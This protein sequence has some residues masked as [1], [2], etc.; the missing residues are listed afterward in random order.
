VQA[1]G[2][3]S[4]IMQAKLSGQVAWPSTG[5]ATWR[6]DLN[7]MVRALG[8]WVMVSALLGCASSKVELAPAKSDGI[9]VRRLAPDQVLATDFSK[10]TDLD[11]P[12]KRRT[13]Y[14][15]YMQDGQEFLKATSEGTASMYRW[16]LA[17]P[18]EE[19]GHVQFSWKVTQ[20]L[21][22]ANIADRYKDD[23]PARL[24]LAFEGNRE[25]FS[26][27]DAVL[28]ELT[29][30][31]TGEPMPYATLMYV[32]CAACT[33]DRVV[34]HGRTSRI[35]YIE[36][37]VPLSQSQEWQHFNRD[38]AKDYAMAFA[39]PMGPLESVGTMTDTDNTKGQATTY[40]GPIKLMA[41]KVAAP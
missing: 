9:V 7:R 22:G 37:A 38:I 34:H 35:R 24:V 17:P 31:L 32:W 26:A 14:E 16:Q 4:F 13:S 41:R 5:T 39:E 15:P 29:L 25:N 30:A 18:V 23:S 11:F 20:P 19:V 33:N 12:A 1:Q 6:D 28:S 10:W 40:F 27:M 2:L 8:A 3:F 21:V 36:L